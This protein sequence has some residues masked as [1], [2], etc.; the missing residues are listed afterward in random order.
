MSGVVVPI[1]SDWT[2][3]DPADRRFYAVSFQNQWGEYPDD[4]ISTV[5]SVV[6]TPADLVVDSPVIGPGTDGGIDQ[7]V[8]FWLTGGSIIAGQQSRL[9]TVAVSIVSASGQELVRRAYLRIQQR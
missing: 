1:P 3:K 7:S 6:A 4:R 2:S 8:G 5:T 9:Y